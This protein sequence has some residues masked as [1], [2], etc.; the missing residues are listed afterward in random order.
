MTDWAEILRIVRDG[1][2]GS[3]EFIAWL[4][5][6]VAAVQ[7]AEALEAHLIAEAIIADDWD[8]G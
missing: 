3:N 5:E 4:R 6:L 2:T 7:R 1:G 8:E